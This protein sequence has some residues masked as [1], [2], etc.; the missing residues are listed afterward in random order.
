MTLLP[1]EELR[2]LFATRVVPYLQS[3]RNPD[4]PGPGEKPRFVS[5]GG[6]PGAGKGRVIE[7]TGRA[8]PGSVVVNGDELRKLHPAYLQ[9]MAA[10][11]LSMPEVTAQA[12]GQWVGMSTQW[13]RG[14]QISAVVETT[15]RQPAVLLREF[16]AFRAAGYVTE[17]C[18]V[19]VPV[20]VSRLGTVSRYVGQARDFGAGRAVTAQGHD[21][22]AAAITS[23]VEALVAS[24]LVDRLVI[25]DR[26][27]RIFLDVD[28]SHGGPE[29]AAQAR[30]VVDQARDV[31][32]MTPQ[33]AQGWFQAATTALK[34]LQ[35]V[36]LDQD[37]LR[38]SSQLTTRDAKAIAA[39][40]WPTEPDRQR[41]QVDALQRH[42]WSAVR[43]AALTRRSSRTTA[44]RAQHRPAPPRPDRGRGG[45]ER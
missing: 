31:T 35:H 20:E 8:H 27:G 1:P 40:A 45:L 21:V 43:A 10:A 29:L 23:T 32:S 6:Q 12:A 16:E 44:S 15:L 4:D 25:Q 24:G 13:L 38:V 37:L 11:P 17:L 26:D 34:A 9:V 42:H 33:Q 28:V 5:V 36:P 30:G 41:H 14:Q 18:V 19:A 22:P 3:I 39:Q 2:R 7:A